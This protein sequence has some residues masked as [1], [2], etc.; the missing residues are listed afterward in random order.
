MS[1][2]SLVDQIDAETDRLVLSVFDNTDLDALQ[3]M[4]EPLAERVKPTL[5]YPNAMRLP[6]L[7]AR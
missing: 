5:P 4:L 1:A 3:E 7:K 6:P 2:R